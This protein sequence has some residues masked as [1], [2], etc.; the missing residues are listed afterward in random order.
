MFPEDFI[1]HMLM[2]YYLFF[3]DN[4]L[5]LKRSYVS[6]QNGPGV[7]EL[8]N[9]WT[10]IW[11]CISLL[12]SVAD[13]KETEDHILFTTTGEASK[14]CSKFSGACGYRFSC[15]NSTFWKLLSW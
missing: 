11:Y 8:K 14:T 2:L 13:L 7:E 4:D 1:Y 3:N 6:K 15:S 12:D 5:T 10:S 9:F